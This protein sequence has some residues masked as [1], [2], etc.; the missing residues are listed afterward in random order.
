[1]NRRRPAVGV[2]SHVAPLFPV[3]PQPRDQWPTHNLGRELADLAAQRVGGGGA[4]VRKLPTV[5]SAAFVTAQ[6]PWPYWL[7]LVVLLAGCAVW[8]WRG[9]R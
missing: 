7:G 3:R 5:T 4:V 2:E 1:M 6:S 9:E 8:T